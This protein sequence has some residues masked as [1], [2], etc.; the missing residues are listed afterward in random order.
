VSSENKEALDNINFEKTEEA[1]QSE[2]YFYKTG[3]INLKNLKN[4]KQRYELFF[5]EL[6]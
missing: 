3:K 4:L 5:A 2:N 1:H 6:N